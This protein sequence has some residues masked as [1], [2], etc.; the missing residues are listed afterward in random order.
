MYALNPIAGVIDGFRWCLFGG[1]LRMDELAISSA[2]AVLLLLIGVRH[3]RRT[4]KG[5]AD[6]I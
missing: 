3:F 2:V 4:E 6:V 1:E 5:F